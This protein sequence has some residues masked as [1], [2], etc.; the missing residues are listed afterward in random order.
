MIVFFLPDLRG[1]GAERV[2]L[3]LLKEFH[4]S[5]AQE[6][7]LLLGTKTGNLINQ[8]PEGIAVHELQASSA[9]KSVIPFIRYCRQYHPEKVFA[10]LGS[11]LATA[12]AKPFI[13]K[14][15]E[16][17]NRLGNTIGAEKK[18]F[19]SRIKR[20]SYIKAN[21]IIAKYSDKVIFQCHYMAQDYIRETG[22]APKSYKVIYNPVHVQHVRMMSETFAAD[23]ADFVAVGR[24]SAQ[25]DYGTLI[26]AFSILKNKYNS[27]Y[28][29]HILGDGEL[30]QQLEQRISQLSLNAQI[31]IAGFTDN[32]Y[33]QMRAA[34]ALISSSLYEGFSNVIVESLC[35]GT[36][37]I[38]S[39][40]PGANNEV[41][42]IGENGFLFKT[43]DAEDLA[44]VIMEKMRNI[45]ILDR[46]QI[47]ERA[48][49]RFQISKIF[50]QYK[51]YINS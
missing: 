24:L 23:T 29:L 34:K 8:I 40:C 51:S 7:V 38:A 27:N 43:G 36:P 14:N 17:I 21:Q 26:E 9:L 3:N 4:E 2:M 44:A 1:G 28:T 15:I 46:T 13:S 18:L 48:R 35:I 25:K 32:P 10:S 16:I 45:K 22:I 6:V 49:E 33:S 19:R 31:K 30:K 47:A 11:S 12:L 37:V 50:S 41:I 5:S 39:D 42:H 20:F